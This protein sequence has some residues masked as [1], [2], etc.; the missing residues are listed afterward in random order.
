ME[1]YSTRK[2]KGP[3]IRH[4]PHWG[5][6]KHKCCTHSRIPHRQ[7]QIAV[8]RL[9]QQHRIWPLPAQ[10]KKCYSDI[11]LHWN[12]A[13]TLHHLVGWSKYASGKILP[14]GKHQEELVDQC[15]CHSIRVELA[16]P[17]HQHGPWHSTQKAQHVGVDTTTCRKNTHCQ[18]W[19][20]KLYHF[21]KNKTSLFILF[22][23]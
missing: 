21:F 13:L 22:Y 18:I 19:P 5:V 11:Q 7:I 17:G 2:D 12:R 6:L 10:L 4:L 20:S 3:W 23:N 15:G 1:K 9:F 8:F 14:F 16:G